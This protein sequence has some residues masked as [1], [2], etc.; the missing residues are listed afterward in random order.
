MVVDM[1]QATK[2]C[3]NCGTV[4]GSEDNAPLGTLCEKCLKRRSDYEQLKKKGVFD[5]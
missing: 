1:G 5:E 4:K 2:V 3:N